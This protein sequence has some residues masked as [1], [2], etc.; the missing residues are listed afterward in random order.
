VHLVELFS[1]VGDE[2]PRV[3]AARRQ[4]SAALF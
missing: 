4:L 1:V 3:G 2:D